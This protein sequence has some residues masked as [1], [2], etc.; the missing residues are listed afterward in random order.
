MISLMA[1]LPE[2]Q[3]TDD[4]VKKG[5]R[6]RNRLDGRI[7]VATL[8]DY[9]K[10]VPEVELQYTTPEG[11]QYEVY[12]LHELSRTLST[13]QER[14][15]QMLLVVAME[16]RRAQK[17]LAHRIQNLTDDLRR[18]ADDIER[19]N[20]ARVQRLD[21]FE[22]F[23]ENPFGKNTSDRF[24]FETAAT[25]AQDTLHNF[26]WMIPNTHAYDLARLGS[27]VESLKMKG[28]Y[29]FREYTAT[30]GPLTTEQQAELDRYLK[31]MAV[32]TG[33]D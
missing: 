7:G 15:F 27:E 24:S 12:G 11:K 9:R 8:I 6:L 20:L 25:L 13:P 19:N 1:E 4:K 32:E 14:D 23:E 16:W 33:E 17:N 3:K 29:L 10:R 2:I 18:K 21:Q 26:L 22:T 30:Y 28:F 5:E 31:P